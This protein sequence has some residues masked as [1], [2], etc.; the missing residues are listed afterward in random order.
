MMPSEKL[1]NTHIVWVLGCR[2]EPI[3]QLGEVEENNEQK[4]QFSLH[5]L[6]TLTEDEVL[7][8]AYFLNQLDNLE[9][10]AKNIGTTLN[11]ILMPYAE[12][13]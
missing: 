6:I 12:M 3:Q 9:P 13:M 7:Y 8:G 11:H 2:G 10:E 5:K 1:Y 4:S